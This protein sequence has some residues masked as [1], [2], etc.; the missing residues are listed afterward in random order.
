VQDDQ[1]RAGHGAQS[2][3]PLC[4]IA[5]A[6]LDDVVGDA[7]GFALV[8][9][10]VVGDLS[11]YAECLCVEWGL[12]DEAIGEGDPQD[13]GNSGGKTKKK[14]VP[15]ESGWFAKRELGTLGY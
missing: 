7:D 6:L 11:C 9:F 5:D 10:V 14:N 2:Q 3:N 12:R 8:G 13:T 1:E 15:V 4:E